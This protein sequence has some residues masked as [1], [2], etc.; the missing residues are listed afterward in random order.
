MEDFPKGL[1]ALV[2]VF[3]GILIPTCLWGC[4]KY[5]VYSQQK[6][7]EA[8]LRHAEFSRQI[9]VQEAHAKMESAKMLADAEV[10]RAQGVARAN[11]IIGDSLKGN[12]AYLR[13]LW[14]QGLG[15]GSHEVIY[16]PT[17]ANLPILEANRPSNQHRQ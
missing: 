12:D 8:E 16:V 15:S 6:A 1:V 9:A 2:L 11:Q 14:V 7:G 10:S 13:Y 17:E 4:P 5:K 3:I